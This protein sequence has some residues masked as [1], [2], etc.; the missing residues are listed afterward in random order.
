MLLL[1]LCLVLAILAGIG[2]IVVSQ[3]VLK[4]QIVGIIENR[5]TYSNNWMRAEGEKKKLN[6]ELTETQTKL[7]STQ[8]DLDTTKSALD[9]TTKQLAAT[10]KLA[11]E[12]A[13]A[14]QKLNGDLKAVADKLAA[15]EAL[16]LSVDQITGL[17]KELK[18]IKLANEGL[19]EENKVI[20]KRAKELDTRLKELLSDKELDPPVPA[21]A[22]GRVLVVVPKWDFL[23]LDVGSKLELPEKGVL[24]VSRDGTLVAKI[25]VMNVQA[26]RSIANIMPGWKLKDVM[27][28]DQVFPYAPANAQ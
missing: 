8:N 4:P 12:R 13:A 25:R 28:G 16:G 23:V 1:R 11:N 15:W 24:L 6:K 14:I 3:M 9:D 22:R 5:T 26:D 21:K 18:D 19:L 7:K 10:T 20:A 17:I 27:E 2:V